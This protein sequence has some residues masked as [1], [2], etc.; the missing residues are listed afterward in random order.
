MIHGIYVRNR[1][2]SKWHLFSVVVS[3]EAA[4][5][6]LDV[7]LKYAKSEGNE[8]AE[9]GVQTFDSMLWVRETMN[10]VK[11]QKPLYN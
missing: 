9:V 11:N 7:A 4:N 10:E 6:E 5:Q 1:P 2:K 3:A 8:Q